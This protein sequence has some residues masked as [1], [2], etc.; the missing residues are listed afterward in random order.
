MSA[1]VRFLRCVEKKARRGETRDGKS[2]ENFK[3]KTITDKLLLNR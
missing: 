1:E 2:R 3:L